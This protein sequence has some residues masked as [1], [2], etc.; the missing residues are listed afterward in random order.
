MELTCITLITFGPVEGV[1]LFTNCRDGSE[2]V[3]SVTRAAVAGYASWVAKIDFAL[4]KAFR[5]LA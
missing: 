1:V 5:R 3:R 4:V 2:V